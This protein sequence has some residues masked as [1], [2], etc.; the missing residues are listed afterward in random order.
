MVK[1]VIPEDCGNAPKKVF[2]RDFN[3]AFAENKND[4]IGWRGTD[5]FIINKLKE[6]LG[7][8][9]LTTFV[10]AN[11]PNTHGSDEIKKVKEEIKQQYSGV[12]QLVIQDENIFLKGFSNFIKNHSNYSRLFEKNLSAIMS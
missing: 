4:K 7:N 2:I 5:D 6:K 11:K 12:P 10:I 8:K 9:K 3:I 1:I